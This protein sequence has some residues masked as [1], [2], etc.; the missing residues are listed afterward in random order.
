MVCACMHSPS[1]SVSRAPPHGLR[2]HA[3]PLPFRWVKSYKDV[4][5]R[6]REP[7]ETEYY[8]AKFNKK[9]GGREGL[10]REGGREGGQGGRGGEGDPEETEYYF[11][12]FAKKVLTAWERGP[13]RMRSMHAFMPMRSPPILRGNLWGYGI[14]QLLFL[15]L[16]SPPPHNIAGPGVPL[17]Q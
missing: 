2:M 1:P 4:N 7:E 14:C 12:K 9:V 3:F 5:G 11:A 16:A 8:Y 6:V 10:G 17:H 13:A 15:H